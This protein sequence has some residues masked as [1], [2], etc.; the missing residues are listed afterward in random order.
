[1]IFLFCVIYSGALSGAIWAN[2]LTRERLRAHLADPEYGVKS[3]GK[4]KQGA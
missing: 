3:A 4:F 1:M 2:L